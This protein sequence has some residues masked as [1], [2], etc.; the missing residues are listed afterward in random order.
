MF[1]FV[2]VCSICGTIKQ[3]EPAHGVTVVFVTLGNT[4]IELLEPLG[5]N[6]PIQKFLANN[7]NGGMHH[8]CVEV[9]LNFTLLFF[10]PFKDL[11]TDKNNCNK[12]TMGFIC[13]LVLVKVPN[14]NDTM[15]EMKA[16]GVRLL[17]N[18]P[19]IGAHKNPVVFVHPKSLSGVLLEFEEVKD[20]K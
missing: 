12:P 11:Q 20:T 8:I 3:P 10:F 1:F 19:A 9:R 4:K 7:P 2:C 17:S 14:I 16:K 5:E 6:S 18:A 15:A 13:M